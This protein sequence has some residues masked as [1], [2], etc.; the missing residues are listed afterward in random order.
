LVYRLIDPR[1]DMFVARI[2]A[3]PPDELF[4]EPI[5]VK[6]GEG[7]KIPEVSTPLPSRVLIPLLAVGLLAAP[8]LL[9]AS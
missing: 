9:L 2:E 4:D 8:T 5:V 1:L 3:A 6:D 7:L